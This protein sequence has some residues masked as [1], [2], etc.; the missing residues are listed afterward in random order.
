[1]TGPSPNPPSEPRPSLG[2]VLHAA[3]VAGGEQRPRPWPPEPWADR[4]ARLKALD[5]KMAAAVAVE[6]RR[7]IAAEI[8]DR[9]SRR[10]PPG[11]HRDELFAAAAAVERAD[12]EPS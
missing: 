8:Q 11:Y 3:R 5:E 12:A 4:D 10:W 2:E 6:V 7:R 1:M 9:A